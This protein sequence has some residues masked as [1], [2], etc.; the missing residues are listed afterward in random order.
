MVRHFPLPGR[1]MTFA[2]PADLQSVYQQVCWRWHALV[3]LPRH[4]FSSV[5]GEPGVG[6]VVGVS[7][8]CAYS[9]F[10]TSSWQP[11][12]LSSSE[13]ALQQRGGYY[14]TAGRRDGQR[15]HHRA[16]GLTLSRQ[17]TEPRPFAAGFCSSQAAHRTASTSSVGPMRIRWQRYRLRHVRRAAA[18]ADRR[19]VRKR[20]RCRP[21]A[22]GRASDTA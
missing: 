20:G 9:A 21:S 12:G 15:H 4:L 1:P 7:E 8:L 6:A 16:F 14:G 11:C 10:T 2:F 19:P 13:S 22:R 17:Q 5:Y 18:P 3:R